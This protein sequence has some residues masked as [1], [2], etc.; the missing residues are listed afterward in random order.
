MH[1]KK[2]RNLEYV[3]YCFVKALKPAMVGCEIGRCEMI[4]PV[5]IFDLSILKSLSERLYPQEFA[6]TFSCPNED[7]ML[8]DNSN[9]GIQ[10]KL[11]LLA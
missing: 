9:Y 5:E 8:E 1:L 6:Y 3:P 4:I 10:Y 11:L 7:L 2:K